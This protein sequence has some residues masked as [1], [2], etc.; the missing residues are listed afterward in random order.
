MG[1]DS[2]PVPL[3]LGVEVV[4]S[5]GPGHVLRC[6]LRLPAGS[7]VENAV[8]AARDHWRS[9]GLDADPQPLLALWGRRCGPEKALRD[10]DRVEWLRPLVA[11]PKE[12]RR[13]RYRRTAGRQGGI[14][15]G[16]AARLREAVNPEPPEAPA[17]SRT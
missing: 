7:T 4:R 16:R 17:P 10:G 11:D 8:R 2:R 5:I 13:L 12:A 3:L 6:Q 14:E 9:A 15:R 1:L